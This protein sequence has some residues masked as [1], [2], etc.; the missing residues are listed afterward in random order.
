MTSTEYDRFHQ[1]LLQIE[2]ELDLF[3]LEVN[4]LRV[5]ERI[6]HDVALKLLA[7]L[8]IL[9]AAFSSPDRSLKKYGQSIYLGL[10]NL[11]VRNPFFASQQEILC[12]GRGRR[13]QVDG[14]WWDPF[15]DPL[16]ENVD[17]Q[18]F[19]I[20]SVWGG[21]HVTPERTDEIGYV[22]TIEF[23]AEFCHRFGL[24]RYDLSTEEHRAVEQLEERIQSEFHVD[25]DIKSLI[26]KVIHRRRVEKPLYDRLLSRLNPSLA[27]LVVHGGKESF[28]E[29]CHDLSIPVVEVQHGQI[30]DYSYNYSFPKDRMKTVFP[31]YLLTFG[32]AWGT[33]AELP[34]P[35]DRVISVGYPYLEQE[36][37]RY[38]GIETE[39]NILFISTGESGIDL[40]QIAVELCNSP[41]V[42]HDILYKL[43]PAELS[44]WRE[45]YP[46]LVESDV[47]V[48]DGREVSLYELF[49]KSTAQVGVASTALYEG[50]AFGLDTYLLAAPT[51]EWASLLLEN[52][53]A[54]L[55]RS[56]EEL[57]GEL[58]RPVEPRLSRDELF[59]P[60]ATMNLRSSI[61]T[62]YESGSVWKRE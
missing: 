12:Y 49:A 25:Y 4:G 38:A 39:E 61:E 37:S 7:D 47:Q 24:I 50:F 5:W 14:E 32:D 9:G 13:M 48:L 22:D 51:V 62:L 3:S 20:E 30:S 28:I 1:Q 6:R 16:H 44:D 53:S 21:E 55:V 34:L 57:I 19:Q 40:S 36:I 33:N 10:R 46:W 45:R 18:T 8:E 27:V 29:S 17:R 59:K 60:G 43:H 41:N 56:A 11:G 23:M 52:D 31:D 35:S 54:T 15:L 42:S 2:D 58:Q 26:K